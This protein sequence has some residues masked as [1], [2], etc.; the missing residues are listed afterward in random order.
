MTDTAETESGK[1][2]ISYSFDATFLSDYFVQT[3]IF[4]RQNLAGGDILL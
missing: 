2:E 1:I 4:R 3:T